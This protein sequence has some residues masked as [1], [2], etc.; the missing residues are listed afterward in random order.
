MHLEQ[1]QIDFKSVGN[2]E[3]PHNVFNFCYAGLFYWSRL[4][5]GYCLFE[6]SKRPVQAVD[7]SNV[8]PS[9]KPS[10]ESYHWNQQRDDW[11]HKENDSI[12]ERGKPE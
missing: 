3:R 4:L 8:H 2:F 5:V 6:V 10:P 11:N 1:M 7:P 9:V 12:E